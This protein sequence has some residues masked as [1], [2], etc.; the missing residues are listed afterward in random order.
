MDYEECERLI[1][2]YLEKREVENAINA[3]VNRNEK[4]LI[5]DLDKLREYNADLVN[6][7]IKRPSKVI[8]LFEDHLNSLIDQDEVNQKVKDKQKLSNKTE[9]YK[10]SFTGN[11]G[12]NM[13]SPRGLNA[14]LANQL[15]CIQGIVTRTSIVRPKLVKSYHYCEETKQGTVKDYYDQYSSNNNI[16]ENLLAGGKVLTDKNKGAQFTNNSVPMKDIHGN[17]L[18]FEYGLSEF[19]DFQVI[20]VQE[21]PERTPL[22]QLPRSIEVVLQ[23]DLVDKV[24]PG[25]RMQIVGLFKCVA[26]QSTSFSGN[27]KTVLIASSLHSLT[28]EIN[29][30]KISGDDLREI[31]KIAE[32]NDCIEIL[33]RSLAPSIWGADYIKKALILQLLGGVE[34]NLENGTHL[35]GDINIMLIGDPST[36]KSQFLRHVLSIAPNSINT[37]GR[38]STGVG[39]TAAVVV[40]KDTGERHLEAGAMVL[41]DRG[42]VCIDEFDKMNDADRV[43]IHEVMEQQT[44]TIAKAGIHVSLNARCSV[45]AAANPIFGEYQ[46]DMDASKNIGLPDSLL[47]RFDCV[48]IVLDENSSEQDRKIS[49]RVIKNHMFP[50][51]TISILTGFDD[52]IIEPDIHL[53]DFGENQVYEK[54]NQLLHGKNKNPILTKSFLKKYL[55]YAKKIVEPILS[56][57]AKDYIT[58]CW[59]DLRVEF[60]NN[61]K[62]TSSNFYKAAPVTVRTLETLIRLST[63]HAKAR[64]SK[65]VNIIDCS[66]AE[67][68]LRF[69]FTGGKLDKKI[70]GEIEEEQEDDDYDKD[71]KEDDIG[72]SHGSNSRNKKSQKITISDKKSKKTNIK[73][74]TVDVNINISK[75]NA[76]DVLVKDKTKDDSLEVTDEMESKLFKLLSKNFNK[77]DGEIPVNALYDI[78]K[79]DDS[80][81]SLITNQRHLILILEKLHNK[82]NIF[83]STEKEGGSVLQ[84]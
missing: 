39:L 14:N 84:L 35:R 60:D 46:K 58:K 63:A 6:E 68:L 57:E 19:R 48:F 38:G 67:E 81:S 51:E 76:K 23:D 34:K 4:R 42:I 33:S 36:A 30:P 5:I 32:S 22:G 49:D 65:S 16:S 24:K 66:F 41:G 64:L 31:K 15:V 62:G 13:I 18:S 1:H 79:S 37:T 69:T 80:V 8:G 73:K 70:I 7:I 71:D 78:V 56:D 20:L 10:V 26:S 59:T 43:A 25:D 12:K 83:Y 44:V 52:K 75:S 47:S 82:A 55:F 9:T 21:P 28:T 11:F 61:G 77:F 72:N 2:I 17:P 29:V 27:F 54:F 3:M 45:L 74:S 50:A 53:D 40:D